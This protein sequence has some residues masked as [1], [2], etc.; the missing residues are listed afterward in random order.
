MASTS[1]TS[2]STSASSSAAV[3]PL[4]L[5][6]PVDC[7]YAC[8]SSP[9]SSWSLSRNHGDVRCTPKRSAYCWEISST[10]SLHWLS[11]C[12]RRLGKLGC[13]QL[14]DADGVERAALAEL[15]PQMNISS[16]REVRRLAE[17]AD[18]R[19]SEPTM[20]MGGELA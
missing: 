16:V 17:A 19:G 3:R 2:A 18:E 12:S 14:R 10:S 20:S 5:P 15:S 4:S 7:R 13:E 11:P 6:W 9:T 1:A 8:V